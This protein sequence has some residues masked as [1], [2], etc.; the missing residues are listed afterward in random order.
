MMPPSMIVR[1]MVLIVV[2][3]YTCKYNF[4]EVENEAFLLAMGVYHS[5]QQ[6][7]RSCEGQRR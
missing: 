3:F 6:C 5:G 2:L 7:G 1:V 4:T